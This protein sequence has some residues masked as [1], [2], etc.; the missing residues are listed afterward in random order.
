MAAKWLDNLGI[1]LALHKTELLTLTRKRKHN[2]LEVHLRGHRI[3]SGTSAKYLGII[4]DSKVNFKQHAIMVTSKAG[5]IHEIC[6]EDNAEHRRTRRNYY[7]SFH[8][9]YSYTV[10]KYGQ[11]K[12]PLED[13]RS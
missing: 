2:T 5:H 11:V 10:R 8:M 4:L 12:C 6:A 9:L 13:G 1:E 3:T 7:P